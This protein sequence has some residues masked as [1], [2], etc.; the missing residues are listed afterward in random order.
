MFDDARWNVSMNDTFYSLDSDEGPYNT[1]R[2]FD[3]G[4]FGHRPGIKG[5]YFPMPPVDSGTDFRA[6]MVTTMT[7]MGL[8]NGEASPRSGTVAA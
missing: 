2:I 3:E 6:E 4:N 5:G 1:G 7:E 8:G